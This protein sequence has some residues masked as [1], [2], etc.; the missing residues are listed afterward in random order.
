MPGMI[1]K[2]LHLLIALRD[3][4]RPRQQISADLYMMQLVPPGRKRRVQRYGKAVVGA[5]VHPVP[6]LHKTHRLLGRAEF[7]S[8]FD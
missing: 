3:L 4:D 6:A 1:D 2:M 8:V 5:V 7:L